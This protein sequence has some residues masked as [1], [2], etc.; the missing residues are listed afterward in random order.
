MNEEEEDMEEIDEIREEI[1]KKNLAT[2][3]LELYEKMKAE[4]TF[5][6]IEL[7]LS[8]IKSYFKN[9]DVIK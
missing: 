7:I 1:L 4:L 9:R 6:H 5:E 3:L 8:R 2:E